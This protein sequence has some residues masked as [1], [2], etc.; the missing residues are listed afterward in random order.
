MRKIILLSQK[1]GAGK[2]TLATQLAVWATQQDE[3][4]CIV[5]LDPQASAALWR[6]FRKE[7][8]P[9]VQRALPERLPQV[10]TE[11]ENLGVTVLLVDTPPHLDKTAVEAIR[12]ADLILCPTKPDLLN[13]GAL[14]DTIAL[15]DTAS[16]KEK[17]LAVI[18]DLPTAA[19]ARS[20]ALE[21]ATVTLH[22]FGVPIAKMTIGHS[23]AMVD[24]IGLG[25]GITEKS[26]KN[27][28]AKEIAALWEEISSRTAGG[29]Q[30]EAAQ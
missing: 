14:A 21:T 6:S 23:Q 22:R 13:L 3:L 20:M 19:K 5:D 18:N 16:A 17:A 24:A 4:A 9:L 11:A 26:P 25:L 27:T 15:L 1:G 8:L 10:A 30:K 29:A 7:K 28:A 2:S 12:L